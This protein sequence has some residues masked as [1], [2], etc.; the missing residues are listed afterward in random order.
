MGSAH[1]GPKYFVTPAGTS[2]R[3]GQSQAFAQPLQIHVDFPLRYA[4]L[5]T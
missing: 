3:D 1:R 5:A 2:A 4:I